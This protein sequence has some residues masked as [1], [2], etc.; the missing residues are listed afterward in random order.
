MT[1]EADAPSLPI[2][3]LQL[4]GDNRFAKSQGDKSL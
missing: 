4:W 2:S 1:D 3:G